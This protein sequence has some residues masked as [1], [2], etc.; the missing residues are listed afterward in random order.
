TLEAG[1]LLALYSDGVTE[2]CSVTG[3][4]FGERGLATFLSEHRSRPCAEIVNTLA[5][6]VRSWCGNS[7]FADDFTIVLVRRH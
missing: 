2:A 3:E 5:D 7:S 4:E 1:D 6:H